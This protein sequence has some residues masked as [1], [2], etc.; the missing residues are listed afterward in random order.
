[1]FFR[2]G[3]SSDLAR[4]LSSVLEDKEG[5]SRMTRKAPDEKQRAVHW[6]EAC[7]LTEKV[8][9]EVLGKPVNRSGLHKPS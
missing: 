2:A 6:A 1:L 5:L 8:Y 9:R 4:K 3:D 7:A